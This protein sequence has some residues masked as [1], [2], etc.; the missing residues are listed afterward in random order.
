MIQG[1]WLTNARS[2]GRS[3]PEVEHNAIATQ[4]VVITILGTC[5]IAQRIL[6]PKQTMAGQIVELWCRGVTLP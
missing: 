2:C 1:Y 5:A 3:D 4:C 6:V